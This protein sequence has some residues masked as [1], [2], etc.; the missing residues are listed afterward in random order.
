MGWLHA[1]GWSPGENE[2]EK[3]S[4]ELLSTCVLTVENWDLPRA[5]VHLHLSHYIKGTPLALK[6]LPCV[7]SLRLP[8]F[9][10]L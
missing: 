7:T 6:A 4:S 2:G 1:L 5:P 8:W 9:A 3:W 10:F